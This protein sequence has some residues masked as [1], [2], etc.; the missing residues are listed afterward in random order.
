MKAR[1]M[2]IEKLSIPRKILVTTHVRPDGDAVGSS[3][4]V[5]LA[6]KA[7]GHEVILAMPSEVP[8]YYSWM[9]G[10]SEIIYF[11][12]AYGKVSDYAKRSDL[13]FIVDFNELT[14]NGDMGKMLALLPNERVLIDHHP[15]PEDLFT[16]RFWDTKAAA[17]A[18]MVVDFIDLLD[19]ALLNNKDIA[20]NLY[21]ALIADTGSFRYSVRPRTFGIASLLITAGIDHESVQQG[22]F[23]NFTE[24]RLR[25]FGYCL[26]EKMQ[27]F[28]DIKTAVITV[29]RD[30]FK[31]FGL[32]H[33]DT[34]ML[35]NQAM[36]MKDVQISVL[37]MEME[38]ITKLSFRSKGNL[39]VNTVARKYFSGGGHRQAAGGQCRLN[40]EETVKAV[41]E[42]LKELF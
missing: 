12:N 6:L 3:L 29:T 34:E 23:D 35:V 26:S 41:A 18:E 20:T 11:Y 38:D 42:R 37:V 19:P 16:Y 1:E 7:K 40:P 25:F 2:L 14:R 13:I 33:G 21:A 17:A 28:P 39:A 30:D 15:D 4:A 31:R 32:C 8:Y 9:P 36:S 24:S 27:L 5:Y 22:V 10:A